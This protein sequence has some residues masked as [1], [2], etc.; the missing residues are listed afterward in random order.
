VAK[1]IT[2]EQILGEQGV[3]LIKSRALEMG[4][5]W[6][7]SN[8]SVEAGIDGWIELRDKN[9]GEVANCWLAVQS[10]ARSKLAETDQTV[11]YTCTQK[12]VEY[13]M[14]GSAPVVLVVSRPANDEA[15][16]VSIKDH[17]ED[18]DFRTDRRI[19]FDKVKDAFDESAA[20]ALK[21]LGNRAGSGAYFTPIR[22]EELLVSNLLQVSRWAPTIYH[23]ETDLRD[24]KEIRDALKEFIEW[25]ARE[26]IPKDGRLYS[27]HNLADEPWCHIC[28]V[29]S[30]E[31]FA[32]D[33]WANSESADERR[34]FARM[35]NH[36]LRDIVG[37][38]RMRYSTEHDCYYFKP[39][40]R[41]TPRKV[42]YKSQKKRTSRTVFSAYDAKVGPERIA[43]YR[44]DGFSH[45]F[46]RYAQNWFLEI[47]PT[48]VFT[49]DGTEPD[50][51]R[52]ER[53]SKIKQIE[54][55][56]AVAGRLL[57]FADMLCDE[58]TLFEK[59]YPF[60]SFGEL[61][62]ATVPVGINDAAWSEIKAKEKDVAAEPKASDHWDR[63]QRT[64]FE[65]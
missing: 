9:T 22:R 20:D 1:R 12:D 23:A 59:P 49:K 29:H 52:E 51:Y 50:P 7:P 21:A 65:S 61:E 33:E 11:S 58:E 35:L 60:L 28:D 64:L 63:L 27:F 5:P 42:S 45:R 14:T 31:D 26:W 43:Y 36:C 54:G 4:F 44:H 6:H 38:W 56:G 8:A 39:T 57:M 10:R 30:I 47:T 55:D 48:Y 32:T 24:G 15:W 13:W 18:R 41:L 2:N 19:T 16:W 17:F 46:R 40:P 37:R 34:D 62:S 3:A 53:Q 25:P